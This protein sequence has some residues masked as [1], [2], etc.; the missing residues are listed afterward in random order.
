M[1]LEISKRALILA[2]AA[3]VV[4]LLLGLG[5]ILSPRV[6]G[7]PV[8]LLPANWRVTRYLSRACLLY[9]SPSPRD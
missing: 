2:S 6:D 9:T 7:R 5:Y 3:A 8:L 4:A 1:E